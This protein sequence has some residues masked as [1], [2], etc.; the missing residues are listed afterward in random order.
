M[1]RQIDK[2]Y[3]ISILSHSPS[4]NEE[5]IKEINFYDSDVSDK[6]P[7]ER[8]ALTLDSYF[9]TNINEDT[10]IYYYREI[11]GERSGEYISINEIIDKIKNFNLEKDPS[12]YIRILHT[13]NLYVI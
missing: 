10:E 7:I 2:E 5:I 6:Q 8:F 1:K 9:C 3:I 12:K 11:I 13:E 4:E